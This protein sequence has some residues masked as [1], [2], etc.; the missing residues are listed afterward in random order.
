M[1]EV[2]KFPME[3]IFE[4]ATREEANRKADEWWAEA[5]GVRF[6][7]RSQTPPAFRSNCTDRWVIA[8]HYKQGEFS[9]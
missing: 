9:S 1:Q 8:I 3:R 2:S 5:K 6:I 4:A 7:H